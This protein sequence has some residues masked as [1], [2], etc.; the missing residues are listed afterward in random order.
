MFFLVGHHTRP[1]WL[2]LKS[3]PFSQ[4]KNL[5]LFV[6]SI[7]CVIFLSLFN[8]THPLAH[9]VRHGSNLCTENTMKNK[10]SLLVYNTSFTLLL[11]P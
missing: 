9:S 3:L 5:F 2:L 11:L 8:L 10:A 4:V 7:I 6:K 1:L